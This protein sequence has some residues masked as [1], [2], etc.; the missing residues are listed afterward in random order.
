MAKPDV[1]RASPAEQVGPGQGHLCWADAHSCSLTS[2]LQLF[3][4]GHGSTE[5]EE[6]LWGGSIPFRGWTWGWGE[7]CSSL[8]MGG[9]PKV[10]ESHRSGDPAT[11]PC[12]AQVLGVS[13]AQG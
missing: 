11:V 6:M 4:A 3:G 8:G 9:D 2:W 12:S 13:G 5:A 1:R 7:V 10:P